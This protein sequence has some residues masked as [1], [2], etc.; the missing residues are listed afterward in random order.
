MV[1]V[2]K[3][4]FTIRDTGTRDVVDMLGGWI[5]WI[6]CP[7]VLF[8]S[9]CVQIKQNKLEETLVD[10]FFSFGQSQANGFNN[11]GP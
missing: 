9:V 2:L 4:V 11:F 6:N 1:V 10:R 3:P 5:K 8:N 7:V